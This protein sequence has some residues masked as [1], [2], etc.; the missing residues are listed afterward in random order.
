MPVRYACYRLA[1]PEIS[2]HQEMSVQETE[3]PPQ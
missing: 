2:R 1:R 3:D